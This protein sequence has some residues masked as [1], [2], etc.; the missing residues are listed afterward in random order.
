[1]STQITARPAAGTDQHIGEVA[2]SAVALGV[3]TGIALS[4]AAN[5]AEKTVVFLV[6]SGKMASGKDTVAPAVMA[7]LGVDSTSRHHYY[8]NALK[9]EVDTILAYMRTFASTRC[10]QAS[11]DARAQL[12]ACLSSKFN[13]EAPDAGLYAGALYTD[14]IADPALHART[15]T[16]VMRHVLQHHGTN[17]RRTQDE[18]YWVARS[19][20]PVYEDLAAGTSVF[21]TDA[22]FPNE[23]ST[24]ADLGG[25]TARLLISADE[26]VRRLTSRD[27]LSVD[28][29]VLTHASET[30]LDAFTGFDVV[31]DNNSALDAT[32]AAIAAAY[33]RA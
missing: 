27:G 12:A 30:A 7:A 17:V 25:Y 8:A 23:I 33:R 4:A 15:R 21:V 14:A 18:N 20:L 22:R 24:A 32:V 19:L 13:L 2:G 1:M 5:L 10:R 9:D 6:I 28:L 16:A 11:P 31:V 3:P 26:Q 29:S